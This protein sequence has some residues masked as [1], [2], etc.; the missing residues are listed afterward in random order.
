MDKKN[1]AAFEDW[2]IEAFVGKKSEY[3]KERWTTKSKVNW[4][5]VFFSGLW[6]LHR[7]M[8]IESM[9]TMGGFLAVGVI[10]EYV[11]ALDMWSPLGLGLAVGIGIGGN[12]LYRGKFVRA[13]KESDGMGREAQEKYLSLLGG[14]SP[15]W[16]TV[17]FFMLYIVFS[18]G[19]FVIVDWIFFF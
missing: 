7:R 16:K 3:Y 1:T 10:F 19:L 6:L 4:A 15:I 13:L 9:I 5:G 8:Y 18:I 2:Q 17:L 12:D 11:F 14:I